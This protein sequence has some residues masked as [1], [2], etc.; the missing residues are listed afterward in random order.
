MSNGEFC[1]AVGICCPPAS[2]RRRQA[3]VNELVHGTGCD[4]KDMVKA[5]DWLIDNVDMLP[6][7]SVNV[8]AI[9]SAMA[10]K[11]GG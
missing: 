4:E 10:S 5:A 6:K 2:I 3:L 11:A 9:V 8:Q 1:C 7:G